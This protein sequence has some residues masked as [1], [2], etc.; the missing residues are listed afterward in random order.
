MERKTN[1]TL[2]SFVWVRG[3]TAKW[4]NADEGKTVAAFLYFFGMSDPPK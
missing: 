2:P 4:P 3:E 1:L